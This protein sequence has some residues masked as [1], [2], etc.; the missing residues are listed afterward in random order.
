MAPDQKESGTC[1]TF[2][3]S[4]VK[5]RDCPPSVTWH[6]EKNLSTCWLA[7]AALS[8]V[9]CYFL[10]KCTLAHPAFPIPDEDSFFSNSNFYRDSPL[11]WTSSWP[12]WGRRGEEAQG[13]PRSLLQRRWLITTHAIFS[14][15]I[16]CFF[17]VPRTGNNASEG[18]NFE[19]LLSWIL[20]DLASAPKL[21]LRHHLRAKWRWFF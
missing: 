19:L 11:S 9:W 13:D 21:L 15:V 20:T 6:F 5:D 2:C 8:P 16:S 17:I 18:E 1:D 14:N 10:K 12:S 7:K 4:G 3:P